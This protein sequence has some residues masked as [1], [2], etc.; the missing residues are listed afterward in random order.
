MAKEQNLWELEEQFWTGGADF[1]ER[2]LAGDALMVF[3]EPAGVVDRKATVESI[4]SGAR[5][6]RVSFTDQRLLAPVDSTA[7]LVYA[8]RA[9]RG[10]LDTSYTA[11]CSSTYVFASGHWW[12][13]VHQ[14]T[15]TG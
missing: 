9:D 6:Q 4:R 14:Q 10:A 3:P 5:W 1:Y 7:I 13:V 2:H 11:R 12:L 8:V 15:P